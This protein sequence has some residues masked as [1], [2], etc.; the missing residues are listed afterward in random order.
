MGVKCGNQMFLDWLTG[1][2]I[3]IGLSHI[4]FTSIQDLK[5]TATKPGSRSPAKTNVLKQEV[6]IIAEIREDAQAKGL[7]TAEAYGKGCKSL[8]ACP[9]T[10]ERPR[11][12]ICLTGIGPKTVALL[13]KRWRAWCM[14]TGRSIDATPE[15]ESCPFL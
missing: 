9:V 1:T 12:L 6:L 11:D 7:K 13:E 4:M 8:A 14:E 15:S 2:Y 5:P 3:A 10:Y